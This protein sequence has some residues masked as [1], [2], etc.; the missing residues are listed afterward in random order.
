VDRS[1]VVVP[2]TLAGQTVRC[3]VALIEVY[4]HNHV[5]PRMARELRRRRG[6]LVS[7]IAEVGAGRLSAPRL[8]IIRISCQL[9]T[10]A[11]RAADSPVFA[12]RLRRTR[13]ATPKSGGPACQA[14]M[15]LGYL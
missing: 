2:K 5:D 14:T 4:G 10:G 9:E 3:L 11:Q 12:E 13:R 1:R 7:L 15:M 8:L 6:E